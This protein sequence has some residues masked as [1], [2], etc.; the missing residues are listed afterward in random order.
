MQK[1]LNGKTSVASGI[2]L[3]IFLLSIAAPPPLVS[4][5]NDAPS[6]AKW[7]KEA[8]IIAKKK[9]PS[10]DIIDYQHIG[11]DQKEETEIEKFKLWMRQQ[12]VEFGLLISIEYKRD[13]H[14]IIS[15]QTKKTGE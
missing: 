1:L 11:K 4:A 3:L 7:G 14:E 12:E 8:M 6:Y 13:T 15:I 10:A 5:S 2:V 9:Y